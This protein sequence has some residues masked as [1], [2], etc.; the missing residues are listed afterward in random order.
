MRT[1][2]LL[3]T[4]SGLVLLAACG[5]RSTVVVREPEPQQ[6]SAATPRQPSEQASTAA[7]LGIPPGHLPEVGQCRVW[8]PGVPPGQQRYPKS[9]SCLVLGTPPAATWL[10]YRPTSDH[11]IVRVRVIDEVRPTVVRVVRVYRVSDGSWIRDM[12]PEHEPQDN[13][14]YLVSRDTTR[15]RTDRPARR[16]DPGNPYS[17]RVEPITPPP[18]PP[19]DAR[20][21]VDPLD[22]PRGHLPDAGECRVWIPGTPPGQQD[23]TKSRACDGIAA[24]APAGSWIVY[25]PMAHVRH[26][27]VRVVD[28]Y[29]AGVVVRVRI[30]DIETSQ[31]VR[32]EMP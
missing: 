8:V 25:R 17:E 7:K 30:F 10:V 26:I 15:L 16:N 23:K 12:R 19:A 9:I 27:H 28:P 32:E 24:D 22:I 13:E 11:K 5:S 21:A 4:C 18:A 31:L 2:T 20:P 1:E 3:L 14:L 29:R 6:P